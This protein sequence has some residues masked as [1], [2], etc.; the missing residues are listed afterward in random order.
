MG[1]GRTARATAQRST[2]ASSP[3]A[4]F[5]RKQT[6]RLLETGAGAR[7]VRRYGEKREDWSQCS[8]PLRQREEIQ[9]VL[10]QGELTCSLRGDEMK[11]TLQTEITHYEVLGVE[12]GATPAEIES[13][14]RAGSGAIL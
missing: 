6:P 3:P 7:R 10:C 8:L 4:A 5:C 9:K 2:A 1:E 12:R 13:A 11:D 14:F